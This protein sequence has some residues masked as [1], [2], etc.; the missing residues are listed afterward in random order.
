MNKNCPPN[1]IIN[2]K[3]G[4]CVKKD[5]KIGMTIIESNRGKKKI[6]SRKRSKPRKSTRKMNKKS[7]DCPSNKIINPKT[8]RCVKKD[9]K[10]GLSLLGEEKKVSKRSIKTSKKNSKRHLQKIDKL[11]VNL[12]YVKGPVSL[13]E[14]KHPEYDKHI[15]I[16]GDIHVIDTYCPKDMNKNNSE[17][18]DLFLKNLLLYWKEKNPK[19]ILDYF[20][21]FGFRGAM[22]PISY[23]SSNYKGYFNELYNKF[24]ECVQIKKDRCDFENLRLHYSDIRRGF[25][26]TEIL[27]IFI[28]NI[29]YNDLNFTYFN[30]GRFEKLLSNPEKIFRISKVDKQIEAVKYPKVKE[31]LL[32]ARDEIINMCKFY[33]KNMRKNDINSFDFENFCED[34]RYIT[35]KIMDIYLF[36]RMFKKFEPKNILVYVGE[37]HAKNYREWLKKLGFSTKETFSNVEHINFQCVNISDFKQPFFS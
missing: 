15:Y 31:L 10:I 36:A 7:S 14:H 12:K 23:I 21:E 25:L 8:G 30:W 22:T 35:V 29:C 11:N 9:G 20:I 3:T 32:E 34:L 33:S 37:T 27:N 26:E 24:I 18:F 6:S 13:S 4:R 17:Y 5:G 1:K 19:V 16:F 2:P 28:D